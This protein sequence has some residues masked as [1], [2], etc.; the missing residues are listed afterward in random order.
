MCAPKR[1]LFDCPRAVKSYFKAY[2]LF[3]LE[4]CA[5]VWISSGE[6]YM[7]LKDSVVR[8]T[9]RLCEVL[10]IIQNNIVLCYVYHAQEEYKL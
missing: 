4:Y 9:E 2:I 3:S 7:G 1:K 6:S 10:I 5:S 8:R